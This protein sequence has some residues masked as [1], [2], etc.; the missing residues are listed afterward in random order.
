MGW[1]INALHSGHFAL[2]AFTPEREL[3]VYTIPHLEFCHR[4]HL[5]EGPSRY[6]VYI[7]AQLLSFTTFLAN[8]KAW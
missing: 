7:L 3:L 8:G 5:D 1:Q 2:A 6:D 4:L